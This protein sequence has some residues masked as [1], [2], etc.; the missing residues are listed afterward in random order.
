MHVTESVIINFLLLINLFIINCYIF[1]LIYFNFRYY[2]FLYNNIQ[3]A[4]DSIKLFIID[5]L[6]ISIEK[7]NN[8]VFTADFETRIEKQKRNFNRG[9][10][11]KSTIIYFLFS[12]S[13]LLSHRVASRAKSRLMVAFSSGSW[14]FLERILHDI[15]LSRLVQQN[16]FFR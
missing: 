10:H 6:E 11:S 7:Q 16:F 15:A 13:L 8:T 4:R 2:D 12:L 1:V 5:L 9:L 14:E 3:H